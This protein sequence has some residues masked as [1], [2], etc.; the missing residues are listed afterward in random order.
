M[1]MQHMAQI[2]VA[3]KILAPKRSTSTFLPMNHFFFFLDYSEVTINPQTIAHYFYYVREGPKKSAMFPFAYSN[4]K[5]LLLNIK[6]K[7]K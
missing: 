2:I 5:K 4:A 6:A 7:I 1:I 3:K